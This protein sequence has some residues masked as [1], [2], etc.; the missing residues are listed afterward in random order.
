MS[1]FMHPETKQFIDCDD[2]HPELATFD[3]SSWVKVSQADASL[4]LTQFN[5]PSK[6]DQALQQIKI[7]E[8]SVTAR[9]I[10]EATLTDEGKQWLITVD[11]RITELRESL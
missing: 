11:A 2:A 4:L 1:I 10:R 7:L 9:R 8:A 6:K 3:F 5:A